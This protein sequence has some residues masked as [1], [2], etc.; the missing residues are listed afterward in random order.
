[1]TTALL[2]LVGTT[3]FF[4][5][6]AWL[7]AV[8]TRRGK[9]LFLAMPRRAID[10]ALTSLGETLRRKLVYIGRY[11]IT[12]S[13]YYSLHTFLRLTLQF[14]AGI[15]TILEAVLHR[16]RDKA[17]IIRKERKQAERSHLTVLNEHK[18]DTE[19]TPNQKAKRKAKA[20]SGK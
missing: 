19:L 11:M 18:A 17:R 15:Y 4:I 2:L 20:L 1:M 5:L 10:S 9:R 16:N 6:Y 8:E 13:W 14:I 12:L 3:V 7:C